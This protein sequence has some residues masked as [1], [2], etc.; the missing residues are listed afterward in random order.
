VRI[1]HR[2][3]EPSRSTS[4]SPT[5]FAMKNIEPGNYFIDILFFFSLDFCVPFCFTLVPVREREKKEKWPSVII[6]ACPQAVQPMCYCKN[7]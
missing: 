3:A 4:A 6:E 7:I 2:S 1:S 5:R